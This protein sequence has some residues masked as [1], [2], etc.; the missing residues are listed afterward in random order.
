MDGLVGGDL[1]KQS[2]AS[3]IYLGE[4]TTAKG[5]KRGAPLEPM[6]LEPVPPEG[7]DLGEYSAG[8]VG[9]NVWFCSDIKVWGGVSGEKGPSWPCRM[10]VLVSACWR[11]KFFAVGYR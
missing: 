8:F 6:I 1:S 5:L 11:C 7:R 10:E 4:V 2:P 9:G 3:V